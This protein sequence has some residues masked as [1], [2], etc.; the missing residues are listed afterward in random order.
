MIL[1][2]ILIFIIAL[3]VLY[4]IKGKVTG[5]GNSNTD[6]FRKSYHLDRNEKP[7]ESDDFDVGD[8]FREVVSH[9]MPTDS[10]NSFFNIDHGLD[11][12]QDQVFQAL[13]RGDTAE[14][15]RI[16]KERGFREDEINIDYRGPGDF[17]F[18]TSKS[19]FKS[20]FKTTKK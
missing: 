2:S 11:M 14:A 7:T 19:S 17:S 15:L 20:E 10:K 6:R 12:N 1:T 5:S 4:I 13:K 18:S 16:L 8:A 3:L 9:V